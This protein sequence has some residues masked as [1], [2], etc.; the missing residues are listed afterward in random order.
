MGALCI[1]QVASKSSEAAATGH[2]LS[3]RCITHPLAQHAPNEQREAEDHDLQHRRKVAP[4]HGSCRSDQGAA[5]AMGAPRP[6]AITFARKTVAQ[7]ASK[8]WRL[9]ILRRA[10]PRDYLDTVRL[11]GISWFK[12]AMNITLPQTTHKIVIVSYRVWCFCFTPVRLYR[13]IRNVL[14]Q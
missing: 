11:E 4:R 7:K 3:R 5:A 6:S 13:Y 10:A 8:R 2:H 12:P 14:L 9:P 1:A